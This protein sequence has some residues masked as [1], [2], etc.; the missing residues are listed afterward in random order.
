MRGTRSIPISEEMV[1]AS[2][3]KVKSNKGVAGVDKR[4]IADF[5]M[6][7]ENNLYMIWNRL[8]SGSYFPPAIREVEIPKKGG[9]LRRLGIP[10]VSDRIAQMVIKNYIEPRLESIFHSNSFG[11]RPGKSAHQAL[12][13]ARENCWKYDWVIDLDIQSFFDEIDHELLR[14]ALEKHVEEKWV[15]MYVARWVTAPTEQK[16]GVLR[17]RTSGTPQGGV[18][19]PLLAN[20]MLHY[21][22]DKWMAKL[23]TEI[24]FER[25]ADDMIVHCK[26]HEEAVELLNQITQRFKE[27]KLQLHPEKTKI[28]YCRDSNRNKRGQENIQFDYLGYCFKPRESKNKNGKLFYSFSPAI[29][30]GSVKRINDEMKGLKLRSMLLVTIEV[31]ASKLNLKIRGWIGYYGKYRKSAL[32]KIFQVLNRRLIKWVQNKYKRIHQSIY[33]AVDWLKRECIAKP[34][35]FTHWEHGYTP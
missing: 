33:H 14:K 28:V 31:I 18:I 21:S 5:D 27:C 1:K 7:L 6:D 17:E 15:L 26:T 29:S 2:Y 19:S 11:Y 32:N 10:T 16:D 12:E 4:S 8:S 23:H 20:L 30:K 9:K 22:F 34:K 3:V 13:Q 25:Y 24:P 35:L